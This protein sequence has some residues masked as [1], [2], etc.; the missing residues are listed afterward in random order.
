MLSLLEEKGIDLIFPPPPEAPQTVEL[1]P[2]ALT[3]MKALERLTST[4]TPVQ[5]LLRPVSGTVWVTCGFGGC[6]SRRFW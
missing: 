2:R 3:Y 1:V 4:P 6:I 5:M